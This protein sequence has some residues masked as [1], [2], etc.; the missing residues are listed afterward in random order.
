MTKGKAK[1]RGKKKTA[2]R[3]GEENLFESTWKKAFEAYEFRLQGHSFPDIGKQMELS[4]SYVFRLCEIARKKMLMDPLE[5]LIKDRLAL[6]DML[7]AGHIEHA[8]KGDPQATSSILAILKQQDS[9]LDMG[10]SKSK[11][12]G[13][14]RGSVSVSDA[15][16]NG[17]RTTK[18]EIEF[19]TPGQDVNEA[20]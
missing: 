6:L 10:H 17:E 9:Y 12:A 14:F 3:S 5:G 8:I 7:K 1:V 15:E 2:G 19:V 18:F 16:G 4:T 13:G 11:E 20:A